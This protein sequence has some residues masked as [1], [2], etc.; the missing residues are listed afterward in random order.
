MRIYR[1][2]KSYVPRSR[3]SSWVFT[4]V[5]NVALNAKRSFARRRESTLTHANDDFRTDPF[6]EIE[7]G[8]SSPVEES[9]REERCGAVRSAINRLNPR[10]Q[11]AMRL[12]NLEG[13]SHAEVADQMETTPEAIKSLLA[14]GRRHL[15]SMLE[16]RSI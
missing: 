3:F 7:S 12:N 13:L 15:R 4:I 11:E 1:A 14:R 8:H 2:R 5:H 9:L 6:D 10:Q 16:T